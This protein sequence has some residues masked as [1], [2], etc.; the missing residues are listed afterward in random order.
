MDVAK[1]KAEE[2]RRNSPVVM[3]KLFGDAMT[4]SAIKMGS[5][6][7]EIVS[8]FKNCEQ[9]F[10]VYSVPKSLQAILIFK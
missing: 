2:D 1:V 5:D 3:G 8:F 6:P 9:L 10:A 4:A 7:V